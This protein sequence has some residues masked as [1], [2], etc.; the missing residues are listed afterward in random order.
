VQAGQ[1]VGTK[2]QPVERIGAIAVNKHVG[3]V[4][5]PGLG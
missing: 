3:R 4:G 5:E 2:A 1:I